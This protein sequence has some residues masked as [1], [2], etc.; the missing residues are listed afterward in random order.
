MLS[1]AADFIIR[2]NVLGLH[3]SAF[4]KY[5]ILVENGINAAKDKIEE[6][7]QTLKYRKSLR[8]RLLHLSSN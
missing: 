8:Y 3:W 6:L 7:K 2:P 4:D 5:D 1:D